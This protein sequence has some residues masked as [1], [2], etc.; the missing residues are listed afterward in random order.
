[1]I[2]IPMDVSSRIHPY[3]A[4]PSQ[5]AAAGTV[6]GPGILRTGYLS[7]QLAVD[8]GAVGGAPTSF[9]IVEQLQHSNDNGST[10]PWTN[11]VPNVGSA[12]LTVTAAGLAYVGVNLLGAKAYVR[13]QQT[14]AFVGGTSPTAQTCGVLT[15]GGAISDPA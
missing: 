4:I 10:D 11:F 3:E 15:L 6:N 13:T 9:S 2:N 12:S 14:A 8:V 1:M 5:A 7:A